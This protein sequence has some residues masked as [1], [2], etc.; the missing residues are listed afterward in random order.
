MPQQ[1]KTT[2]RKYKTAAN[3][4]Y[5]KYHYVQW[6]G[7]R[8]WYTIIHAES[9]WRCL[10]HD[11]IWSNRNAQVLFFPSFIR[12]TFV[13]C[14]RLVLWYF[15]PWIVERSRFPCSV[16]KIQKFPGLLHVQTIAFCLSDTSSK[17]RSQ[18]VSWSVRKDAFS[19][20]ENWLS[21]RI[22]RPV[23]HA[24]QHINAGWPSSC[25]PPRER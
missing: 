22:Q 19:R 9:H 1:R 25:R 4:L 13:L 24:G 6:S 14:R 5:T 20:I 16:C 10:I 15:S 23:I 21:V 12:Y 2:N 18:M 11:E 17:W 7:M 8:A 3:H